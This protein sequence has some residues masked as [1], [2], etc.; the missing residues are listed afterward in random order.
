MYNETQKVYG[1]DFSVGYNETHEWIFN[2][3]F[4]DS[5]IQFKAPSVMPWQYY[6]FYTFKEQMISTYFMLIG[7]YINRYIHN[8]PWEWKMR[9]PFYWLYDADRTDIL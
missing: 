4:L 9:P 7:N 8:L 6:K 3:T 2:K 5:K 1:F